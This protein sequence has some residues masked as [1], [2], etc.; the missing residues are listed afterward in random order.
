MHPGG[1]YDTQSSTYRFL[2]RLLGARKHLKLWAQKMR[3]EHADEHVLAYSKGRDALVVISNVGQQ[4]NLTVDIE[5]NSHEFPDGTRFCN[6]LCPHMHKHHEGKE[7][8]ER[9]GRHHH[10][11]GEKREEHKQ[12]Q[13]QEEET[14]EP[15][16][17]YRGWAGKH[18]VIKP[19]HLASANQNAEP[20]RVS[21]QRLPP[22]D[23][24][25]ISEASA[26]GDD[27][28]E[29][30]EL[31][32]WRPHKGQERWRHEEREEKEHHSHGDGEEEGEG[33]DH[34]TMK[35]KR[36]V[37]KGGKVRVTIRNGMPKL[38]VKC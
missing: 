19:K 34:N 27:Q 21:V 22:K 26:K 11:E 4:V 13:K 33:K 20:I 25:D 15:I 5:V 9:E 29:E 23:H 1:G 30:E 10:E 31:K 2:S 14:E 28:K 37:V 36:P 12:E 6:V 38:L 8:E 24:Q 7:Q 32:L 17:A 35:M 3:I 18:A 16:P